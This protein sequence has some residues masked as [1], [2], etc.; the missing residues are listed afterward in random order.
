MPSKQ[1][2]IQLW[3]YNTSEPQ[4]FT[5]SRG[6]KAAITLCLCYIIIFVFT[7]C[8]TSPYFFCSSPNSSLLFHFLLWCLA[9]VLCLCYFVFWIIIMAHPSLLFCWPSSSFLSHSILLSVWWENEREERDCTLVWKMPN[10]WVTHTLRAHRCVRG[11]A[12]VCGSELK[13]GS[14]SVLFNP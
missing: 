9:L 3:H 13:W 7:C 1:L 10:V 12:G 2:Q 6:F 5:T 11:S 4:A 14:W 8:C